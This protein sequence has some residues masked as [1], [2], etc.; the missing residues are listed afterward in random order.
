MFSG[1]FVVAKVE[2]HWM[3]HQFEDEGEEGLLDF[4]AFETQSL[5]I[6]TDDPVFDEHFLH[7]LALFFLGQQ[8]FSFLSFLLLLPGLQ[9]L[10][11]A[12]Y[13]FL[14]L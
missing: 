4:L 9:F 13:F 12:F 11:E 7:V 6:G 14:Q 10:S 1:K 5:A 3:W 2:G 8:L